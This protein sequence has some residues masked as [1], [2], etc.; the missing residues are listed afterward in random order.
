MCGG[1][2]EVGYVGGSA[3][4]QSRHCN[5]LRLGGES[6][7]L[8]VTKE[9]GRFLMMTN[10]DY[11]TKCR[12]RSSRKAGI[13]PVSSPTVVIHNK[14]LGNEQE[15]VRNFRGFSFRWIGGN[16]YVVAR[17]NAVDSQVKNIILQA[18]LAE[19]T[20]ILLYA[21]Y[22]YAAHPA[23]IYSENRPRAGPSRM[24]NP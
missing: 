23:M 13:T 15:G 11:R 8:R 16:S 9:K 5:P 22:A 19:T 3:W 20:P 14:E 1:G 10:V 12:P 4:R 17:G 6:C 2:G 24:H 21:Y 18:F 7:C